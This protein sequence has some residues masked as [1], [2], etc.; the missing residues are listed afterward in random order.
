MSRIPSLLL[1]VTFG[2]YANARTL[3]SLNLNQ[4]TAQLVQQQLQGS[5]ENAIGARITSSED[6]DN[7]PQYS[8]SYD[9]KDA[10]TGDDKQQEEKRDGD[11]VR[12]QYSLV[13]PDGT[14]RIVE[15][16]ADS[17]NG[18]NAVVSKQVPEQATLSPIEVVQAQAQARVDAAQAQA[19]AQAN[20]AIAQV[21]AEAQ[22]QADAAAAQA[23]A[24]AEAQAAA[25]AAAQAESAAQAQAE[26]RVQAQQII[27][28]FQQQMQEEL[29]QRR[30]LQQQQQTQSIQTSTLQSQN[31]LS[32]SQA[33]L[34]SQDLPSQLLGQTVHSSVISHPPTLVTRTPTTNVFAKSS[35]IAAL[36]RNNR[37]TIIIERLPQPKTIIS[38]PPTATIQTQLLQSPLVI[39]RLNNGIGTRAGQILTLDTGKSISSTIT[40][41]LSSA[42]GSRTL[43]NGSINGGGNSTDIGNGNS[44][45]E[46]QRT[47]QETSQNGNDSNSRQTSSNVNGNGN[48]NGNGN[49]QSK[50]GNG[51]GNG[52]SSH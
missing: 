41:S 3:H 48:S 26:A 33:L 44:S 17:I 43:T 37:R 8:F 31:R 34:L 21:Q 36:D 49:G 39:T 15:Y 6:Y 38:R 40:T 7:H 20:A 27:E 28:Q 10:V 45:S 19:E 50:N 18:F 13:E 46:L 24:A 32:N 12:G 25:I 23:R 35:D 4:A 30:Q 2:I 51:N 11:L 16:T 22:A 42:L 9:V 47:D 52:R 5:Q 29:Q 14:R 1:F